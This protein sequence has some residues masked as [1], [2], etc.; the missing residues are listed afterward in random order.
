M[1]SP[2][3]IFSCIFLEGERAFEGARKEGLSEALINYWQ[4]NYLFLIKLYIG[5]LCIENNHHRN[6][7]V[8]HFG[9]KFCCILI[10]IEILAE[11]RVFIAFWEDF[12]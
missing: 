2:N 6:K 7:S 1:V 9:V 12:H 4:F 8:D 11:A 3:H 10:F 5:A